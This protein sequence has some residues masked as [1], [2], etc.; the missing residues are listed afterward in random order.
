VK[1]KDGSFQDMTVFGFGRKGHEK[2]IHHVADL[3]RM[4][5]RY[6]IALIDHADYATAKAFCARLS[7]GGLR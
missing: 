3:T 7:A 4:P 6:S 1:A 2:L 5:A